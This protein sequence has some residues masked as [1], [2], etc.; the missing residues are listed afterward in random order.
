MRTADVPSSYS[1][2][3]CLVTTVVVVVVVL[4]TGFPPPA[5][6]SFTG[7]LPS[8]ISMP[9]F[10]ESASFTGEEAKDNETPRGVA[11]EKFAAGIES[12]DDASLSVLSCC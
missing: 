11:V 1:S 4:R 9:P 2:V 5:L 12:A 8:I 10:F 7:L 6:P 3:V